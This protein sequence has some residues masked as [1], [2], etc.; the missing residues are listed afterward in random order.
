[1]N[2]ITAELPENMHA[3]DRE[4]EAATFGALVA[5]V[6]AYDHESPF[7]RLHRSWLSRHYERTE[8]AKEKCR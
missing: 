1:L 6:T 2:Y 5:G 3:A 4:V 7:D 8:R